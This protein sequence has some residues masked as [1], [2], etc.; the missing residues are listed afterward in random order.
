MSLKGSQVRSPT[1]KPTQSTNTIGERSSASATRT[2]SH[3]K[4]PLIERVLKLILDI[5]G[6]VK[7]RIGVET[8]TSNMRRVNATRNNVLDLKEMRMVSTENDVL[9]ARPNITWYGVLP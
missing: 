9:G 3:L 8:Q 4:L 1:S 2:T 5:C 6:D 7:L